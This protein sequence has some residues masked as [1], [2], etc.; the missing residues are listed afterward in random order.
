MLFFRLC[1]VCTRSE[2]T[3]HTLFWVQSHQLSSNCALDLGRQ[4]SLI[5]FQET[6]PAFSCQPFPLL[7]ARARSGEPARAR[8]G[9]ALA[10]PRRGS[11]VA[12]ARQRNAQK[13]SLTRTYT[14][15]PQFRTWKSDACAQRAAGAATRRT[16]HPSP[17]PLLPPP[18]PHTHRHTVLG[19]RML[20]DSS[21]EKAAAG[22]INLLFID[23]L[24]LVTWA[25]RLRN[26]RQVSSTCCLSTC[27]F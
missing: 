11:V 12:G 22:F 5:S 2:S 3:L 14:H 25:L 27:W 6:V 18:P 4:C 1:A 13:I 19:R 21:T 7:P 17:P 16:D 9:R 15:K 26:Q 10:A 24:V 20:A 8:R 23:L